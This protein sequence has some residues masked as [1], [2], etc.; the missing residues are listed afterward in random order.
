LETEPRLDHES[1]PQALGSS[2]TAT[3]PAL[4]D[5]LAASLLVTTYQAGKLVIVRA[6]GDRLNTHF[7][8]FEAPMGL[9]V[10]GDRLAV[11]TRRQVWTFRDSPAVASTLEPVGRVD[12]CYLPR[13]CHFTGNVQVHEMDWV[14]DDLWFVNTRFSCLC[15][16]DRDRSFAPRWKPPFVS[17][18]VPEDRCHLNGLGLESDRPRYVTALGATDSR[19]GWRAA[20]ARGGVLIDVR[21][22]EIVAQ[23]LSMPHSPRCHRG[24]VWLLESGTG[25]FGTV[26]VETGRYEPIVALPGFTRGLDFRG[27]IAFIG[28]SKVRETAVFGGLPIT[29]SASELTCGVCAVNL[30]TGR[31]EASLRFDDAVREIFAVRV[32]PD[33]RYPD[34]IVE[35]R[36][37][38]A[39]AFDLDRS[40]LA[41]VPDRW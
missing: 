11:G 32:L 22:G 21:T 31:V 40:S 25:T 1:A 15:S 36:A 2:H 34:L 6:L 14:G 23:G 41:A 18:L 20:K 24:R 29:E 3:F 27:P 16:L 30:D 7:R 39:D 28:L 4:L 12:A 37:L 38:L 8:T 26:D 17:A 13:T 19:A 10:G 9:A 33:R 5:R 35:D